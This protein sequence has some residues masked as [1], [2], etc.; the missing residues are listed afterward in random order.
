MI[1]KRNTLCRYH[2]E[3]VQRGKKTRRMPDT[4]H[5]HTFTDFSRRFTGAVRQVNSLSRHQLHSGFPG[6]CGTAVDNHR[7]HLFQTSCPFPHRP[8]RQPPAVTETALTVNHHD[9]H[10]ALQCVM[11]QTIVGDDH[12]HRCML[13][14]SFYRCGTVWRDRNR[15]T[16]T[17]G[18]QHRLITGLCCR[19]VFRDKQR[20]MI[21]F[22]AVTPGNHP[23]TVAASQ[24]LFCQPDNHRGFAVTAG[25]QIT[26]HHHR[27]RHT[28][29]FFQSA[30]E[31][32][33]PQTAH[34]PVQKRE[35]QKQPVKL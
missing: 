1:R 13:Q 34:R 9:F 5:R 20:I 12:I 7:I 16:G 30:A 10:I 21:R 31:Q 3:G 11:L 32:Q 27:H 2:A 4:G 29:G 6:L 8:G 33:T 35:R 26:D 15:H 18:N 19:R 25:G 24:Q 17:A 28:A 14:N 23:G 22:T